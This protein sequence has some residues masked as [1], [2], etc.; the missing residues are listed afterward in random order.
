MDSK[1]TPDALLAH[2]DRP[3]TINCP[4]FEWTD[5]ADEKSRVIPIPARPDAVNWD[6]IDARPER[7]AH[8]RGVLWVLQWAAAAAV[9]L[10]AATILV[11]FVRMAIAEH[12]LQIAARAALV[13]ATLP[14]ATYQS[15]AATI[16]RKLADYSQLHEALQFTLT[17]NGQPVMQSFRVTEGDDLAITVSLPAGALTPAWLRPLAFWST[18]SP[19]IAH[20]E[21]QV[22]GRKLPPRLV[23]KS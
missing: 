8:S 21:R 6:T 18:S 14:K 22:P 20:A 7:P 17:Q 12:S 4:D 15:I 10:I 2:F 11:E 13:E 16:D 9:L 5:D 3:K 19:L 23:T 1:H